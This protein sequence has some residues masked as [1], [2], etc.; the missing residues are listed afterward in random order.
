MWWLR[1]K[2]CD[3]FDVMENYGILL[4]KCTY[5]SLIYILLGAEMPHKPVSYVRKM[6]EVGLIG[7]YI[8]YFYGDDKL[9]QAW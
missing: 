9:C 1:H 3:L 6:Q 2:T 7:D 8:P 4:L 5:K